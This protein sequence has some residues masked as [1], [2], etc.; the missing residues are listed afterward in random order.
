M[1][2]AV[3]VLGGVKQVVC[4]DALCLAHQVDISDDVEQVN[5]V[6]VDRGSHSSGPNVNPQIL[7]SIHLFL[8]F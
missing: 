1:Y 3:Q 6:H 5:R 2:K 8:A 4:L 7:N